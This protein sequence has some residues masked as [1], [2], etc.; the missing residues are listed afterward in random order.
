VPV[1]QEC[2]ATSSLILLEEPIM[3]SG[4]LDLSA[5]NF[6][7]A[8]QI[9]QAVDEK[10]RDRRDRRSIVATVIHAMLDH[11]WTDDELRNQLVEAAGR[12]LDV[13]VTGENT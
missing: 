6:E 5:S 8:E 11:P 7:L 4:T 13:A 3:P 10:A 12:A 2:E 1:E 9:A